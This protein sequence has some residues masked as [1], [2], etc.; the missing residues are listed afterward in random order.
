M[1]LVAPGC[2]SAVVHFRLEHRAICT[3]LDHQILHDAFSVIAVS[4]MEKGSFEKRHLFRKVG[5]LE[6]PEI[7]NTLSAVGN[8]MTSSERPSPEPL[9]KKEAFPA[10]LRGRELWK[11]YGGF[12]CLEL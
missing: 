8:S 10:V 2:F 9:L 3:G 5:S 12:K 6:I 7:R 1:C 11:C 4:A